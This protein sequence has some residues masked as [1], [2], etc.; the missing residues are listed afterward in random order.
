MPQGKKKPPP[1]K[2]RP[3]GSTRR[4]VGAEA[5][6]AAQLPDGDLS[7]E[8]AA[9]WLRDSQERLA[10]VL[11]R[12]ISLV[13]AMRMHPESKGYRRPPLDWPL[14]LAARADERIAELHTLAARLREQASRQ[15]QEDGGQD[16]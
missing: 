14:K 8:V 7:F 12:E 9:D 6:K 4:R 3:P 5:Y 11:S 15:P 2:G 16:A 13:R 1:A 10:E